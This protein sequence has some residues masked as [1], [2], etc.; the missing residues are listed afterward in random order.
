[1]TED[2]EYFQNKKPGKTYI[3][4]SLSFSRQEDR[5]IRYASK[6]FNSQELHT[7][8]LE[9]GELVLRVTP[10]EKQEIVAKFYEDSRGIYALTIQRFTT[11]TGAPHKTY[12]T[13]VGN[14]ITE[15]LEFINNLKVIELKGPQKVN[16]TDAQLRKMILSQDQ[17]KNLINHNQDLV[18]E[19][20]KSEVT[21]EDIVALGYRKKQLKNFDDLLNDHDF[22]QRIKRQGEFKKDEDVWQA[23]FEKNTWIFG[24]GLSYIFLSNLDDKKLE[25]I[26][27]G[28]DFFSSGKRTDAL[29]KTR[30]LINSLCFCEIKTHKTELLKKEYRP[31]CWA[32]SD[33]LSGAVSQIQ[34]TVSLATRNI[35]ERTSGTDKQGNPTGEEIY[36]YHP[37]SFLVIGNLNEFKTENGVNRNKYR[38]FELFRGNLTSPE[39]ITFDELYERARFIIRNE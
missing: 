24:Y 23:F 28:F 7:F 19:L 5:K 20:A 35:E 29:M 31:S 38:S 37:K 32:V 4:K 33:E 8:V 13:F 9:K 3:S 6:V 30:G 26:V 15:L 16:I 36:N 25:Q 12:F 18:I 17:I 22:F 39:V 21:K 27:K 11:K 10:G 1:M 14:E 34:G 2:Y